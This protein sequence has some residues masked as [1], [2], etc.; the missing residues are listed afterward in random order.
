MGGTCEAAEDA[1]NA[2]AQLAVD[3]R[4]RQTGFNTIQ[5]SHDLADSKS[6]LLHVERPS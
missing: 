3:L 5:G 4:D 2:G 1:F 6:R